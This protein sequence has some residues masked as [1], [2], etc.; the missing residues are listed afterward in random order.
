MCAE[1]PA[2]QRGGRRGAGRV[3]GEEGGVG[4]RRV[5]GQGARTG[6]ASTQLGQLRLVHRARV[7]TGVP[8]AVKTPAK[9]C[10]HDEKQDEARASIVMRAGTVRSSL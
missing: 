8:A 3:P 6:V 4:N 5:L 9:P 1:T 2:R 10:R 7:G